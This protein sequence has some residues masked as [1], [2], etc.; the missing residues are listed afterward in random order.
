MTLGMKLLMQGI[1]LGEVALLHSS[2]HS[3]PMEDPLATGSALTASLASPSA[4]LL[5][6]A[7]PLLQPYD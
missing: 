4:L 2:P 3:Y 5:S 1:T 7:L 6:V